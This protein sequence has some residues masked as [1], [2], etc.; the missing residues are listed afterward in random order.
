MLVITAITGASRRKEPSL[1]SAS[2]TSRSPVPSRVVE[3]SVPAASTRPPMMAVGSRPACA[4]RC[5]ISEVV[6]VLPWEPATAIPSLRRI[7]SASIS[8]RGITGIFRRSASS[9][10]GLL[11]R[12]AEE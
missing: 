4:S 12:T 2:A 6:V 11:R 3:G 8:A 7:T 1:S 10:S 5:A 9:S